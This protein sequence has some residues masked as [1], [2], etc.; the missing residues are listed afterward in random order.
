MLYLPPAY[1]STENNFSATP[2]H[3]AP[4]VSVTA[5]GSA[6]TKG[7]WAQCF[8]SCSFDVY[9][10][11]VQFTDSFVAATSV[12]ILLD[13]G[14]GAAAAEQVIIANILAGAA[15]TGNSNS[16]SQSM[17]YPV[18]IPKGTRI[19]ARIQTNST[20][21]RTVNVGMVLHGGPTSPPWPVFAG[22]DTIGA[23]TATSTGLAHT[24]GNSGAESSWTSIGSATTQ[25]YKAL[26][27]CVQIE[28]DTTLASQGYHL[29]I[30]V[31][32]TTL[33]EFYFVA[34]SSETIGT[35]FPNVPLYVPIPS[36]S[37]LQIRAEA[38]STGEP[39]SYGIT[40]FY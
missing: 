16:S 13:I 23:N 30:G 8:S 17:F 10:V 2:S 35:L 39:L 29:E 28:S 9:G 21:A 38:G 32:S 3:T 11:S 12:L 40:A 26:M 37:Q 7:S 4:G 33:G 5:P 6:H 15:S 24:A 19:A 36:G 14:I 20:T 18:F 34:T 25:H 27:P 22:A 1:L 31:S